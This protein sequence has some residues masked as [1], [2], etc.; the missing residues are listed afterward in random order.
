MLLYTTQ[1]KGND[2]MQDIKKEVLNIREEYECKYVGEPE[3]QAIR[4]RLQSIN[5]Q[6][7]ITVERGISNIVYFYAELESEKY[8]NIMYVE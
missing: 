2:N 7:K 5:N 8:G 4:H 6:A 3:L 1:E